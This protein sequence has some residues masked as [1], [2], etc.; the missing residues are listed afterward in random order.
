MPNHLAMMSRRSVA[1]QLLL[2]GASLLSLAL[3]V[4]SQ[5]TTNENFI[6]GRVTE[7]HKSDN[8]VFGVCWGRHLD[9]HR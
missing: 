2:Q 9:D 3:A 1:G 8:C 6:S 7:C 5:C 4:A